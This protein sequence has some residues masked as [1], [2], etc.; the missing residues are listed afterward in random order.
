MQG[1]E[2]NV[3]VLKQA[4]ELDGQ[5]KYQNWRRSRTVLPHKAYRRRTYHAV[6]DTTDEY[7][8]GGNS[9]LVLI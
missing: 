9:C 2:I 3:T 4:Q 7:P 6:L 1:K 8:K 5:L